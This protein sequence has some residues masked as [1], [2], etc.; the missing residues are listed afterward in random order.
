[1]PNLDRRNLLH[2]GM[3]F[4]VPFGGI[5]MFSAGRPSTEKTASP[6]AG[7]ASV[8]RPQE[9]DKEK[10]MQVQYL[11]IVTPEVDAL[12]DQYAATHGVTF[13]E[14]VPGF[15]N[16]RTAKL[17]SGGMIGIRGPMR[18]DETPVVRPY[19]LVE[20]LEEAVTAAA[21]AGAEVAI[22]SMGIPGGHGTIGIVI[23]GGIE[24]GFW[25]L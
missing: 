24:C 11:E 4:A 7:D 22:Q 9:D 18:A 21:D 3:A 15:G 25:Q 20:N 8:A 17:S 5:T 16:A 13:G 19:M 10:T 14:P 23:Q 1:M 12:C 2:A 6:D